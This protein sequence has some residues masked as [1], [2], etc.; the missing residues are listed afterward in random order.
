[1]DLLGT[2]INQ[3]KGFFD[4]KKSRSNEMKV[5]FVSSEFLAGDR[6]RG[7]FCPFFFLNHRMMVH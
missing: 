1:M 5:H 4:N 2:I 7:V 6:A 3:F